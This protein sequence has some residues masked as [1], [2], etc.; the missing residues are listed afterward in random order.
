MNNP[1]RRRVLKTIG[2]GI[3]G[4]SATGS[5]NASSKASVREAEFNPS[6]RDETLQFLYRTFE[7][8]R[9]NPNVDVE[10][11]RSSLKQRLSAEQKRSLLRAWKE[12]VGFTVEKSMQ[13]SSVSANNAVEAQS[14]ES[15]DYTVSTQIEVPICYHG[16]RTETFDAYDFTH[17]LQWFYSDGE[18]TSGTATCTGTGHDY[19]LVWWAYE[20]REAYQKELHPDG[21][22]VK[23]W[24]QGKFDQNIVLD[25]APSRYQYPACWLQGDNNGSGSAYGIEYK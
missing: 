5:V 1:N 6:R 10:D 22:Y 16:C 9:S 7:H 8:V 13:R 24:R 4:L 17:E 3:A 12:D 18:V 20:G 14:F 25:Q 11:L 15:F 19:A 21:Y 23:T 2:T